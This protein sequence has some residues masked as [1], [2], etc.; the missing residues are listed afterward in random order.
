[1]RWVR[2]IEAYPLWALGLFSALLFFFNLSELPL[3]IME[4]RNFLVAREM[5][6]DNH[7][8]LTTMNG[9]A[10]YEKPPLP[11]WITA[12]FIEVFGLKS[13]WAYRLPTS[14]MSTFGVFALYFLVK[15]IVNDRR[16][17]LYSALI[18]AT[19]FYFLVIRFEAPS[20]MYT[21]AFMV[22]A[23]YFWVGVDSAKS[24]IGFAVFGGLCFGLS[25]LSKGPV[26]PY[27]LFLPFVFA[28]AG[29]YGNQLKRWWQAYVALF[30]ISLAVGA[31]WYV[32]VHFADP[33]G[34]LEV[35]DKESANWTSYNVRPFYYYW[36]FFIQSG[37]W[38]IL[39][40]VSLAFPYFHKR[41]KH[42]KLYRFSWLW[43]VFAVVLL[44]IIPE[45]KSRYL[46]PV[47]IPLAINVA[48][49]V[50][51]AMGTRPKSIFDKIFVNAHY[52]VVLLICLATPFVYFFVDHEAKGFWVW[53]AML[54]LATY[55]I[56]FSIAGNLRR[57]DW[58]A[59][60]CT[61]VLLVAVVTTIG[62]SGI[63]FLKVNEDYR[64]LQT[65]SE[66][67]LAL[68]A[69]SYGGLD[70]EII[71]EFGRT[72]PTIQADTWPALER[73]EPSIV[74]VSAPNRDNFEMALNDRPSLEI[75]DVE[76]FDRNHFAV[77]GASG[78]KD[79][80]LIFVFEIRARD[81]AN[82]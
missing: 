48:Q 49:V 68:V 9:I 20:D 4:A 32:Y 12:P 64:I 2:S 41:V 36:S 82:P 11:A 16:V 23:L 18:L 77:P 62:T 43:T 17:A 34:I 8:L 24:K 6:T 76:A 29:T 51:F 10:R 19:S 21:H 71:W 40:A 46:V 26:S 72:V 3:S 80:H 33:Q 57:A 66:A 65:L 42:K 73:E 1:M 78:Y 56:A 74:L 79:R 59:V 35:A 47:L 15:K 45:K 81:F 61:S 31:S 7:W 39:A 60:L 50:Y 22:G 55:F 58:R 27:A 75:V 38:T 67:D 30:L 28:F 44:S 14:L 5:V 25:V 13:L 54:V 69:Y 37:I 70:P 53:Y 52:A 63:R